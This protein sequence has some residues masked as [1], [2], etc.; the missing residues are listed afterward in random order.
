MKLQKYTHYIL[1]FGHL[2]GL[3]FVPL[4]TSLSLPEPEPKTHLTLED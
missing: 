1:A 3:A 4:L 2:C